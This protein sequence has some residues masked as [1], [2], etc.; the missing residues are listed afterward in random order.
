VQHRWQANRPQRGFTLL[1]VLV[2][3][4]I[5]ALLTSA[6]IL[7]LGSTGKDSGL[8][9]ERDRLAALMSYVRE[10]GA[11]LTIEYGMRC[12]PH[13]YRFVYF[14][15][16]TN[17]WQPETVDETLRVRHLP[18]GLK[19]GLVIEGHQI[20]LDDKNLTIPKALTT[21]AGGK[22][23]TLGA[24]MPSTFEAQNADNSPQVLL[25]SNGD[26]NSFSLTLEREGT[27]RSATLQSKP[28]ETIATGPILEP[29]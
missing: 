19:L 17:Q 16:R 10:R 20:V 9:K 25:L 18:A 28:D 2:V 7:S 3:M 6:A 23:N 29:K 15:H 5:I 22:L 24:D 4:L 8:E 1:E 11:M 14:D 21:P 12:G 13:G 27:R 26:V